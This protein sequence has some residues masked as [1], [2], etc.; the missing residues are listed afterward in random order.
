MA[1]M[2]GLGRLFNVIPNASGKHIKLNDAEAVTFVV[3]EAT[4]ATVITMRE[5]I[6]GA[7]EQLLPLTRRITCT[8]NGSDKWVEQTQSSSSTI[9]KTTGATQN[10]VLVTVTAP[11]LSAGFDSVEC[12]VGSG[13]CIAIVHDLAVQRAPAQL[14]IPTSA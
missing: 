7:S 9:T 5:S 6:A 12:T 14:A 11:Q 1:A 10:A 8:G 4:T 2:E 13:Q 3:F